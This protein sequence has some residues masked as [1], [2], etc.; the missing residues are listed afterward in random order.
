MQQII[1]EKRNVMEYISRLEKNT[2]TYITIVP[3]VGKDMIVLKSDKRYRQCLS[4]TYTVT[5][6]DKVVVNLKLFKTALKKVMSWNKKSEVVY[7]TLKDEKLFIS[8]TDSYKHCMRIST[9][10]TFENLTE[11]E[12]EK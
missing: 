12:L 3:V 11:G 4:L 7:V 5:L 2:L 1:L 10:K 8:D 6:K 9:I